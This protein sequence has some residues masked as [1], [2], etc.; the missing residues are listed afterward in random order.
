MVDQTKP[1]AHLQAQNRQ[2]DSDLP[3]DSV[4]LAVRHRTDVVTLVFTDIVGSTS[5]KHQLGDR[6]GVSL[7]QRHHAV[8]RECLAGFPAGKEDETAGDSFLIA[9]ATPSAAVAFALLLQARMRGFSHA[10]AAQLRD[11]IGIHLGEVV[12]QEHA[13]GLKPRELYGIQV[14]TCARVMDLAQAGQILLTR[15]A[16]DSARQML[17]GEDVVG[18]GPLAWLNHGSYLLKGIEASL[19]VCE[20]GEVGIAPLQAP[21]GSEKAQRQLTPESEAVLGWRPAV[22]QLVP[23][24]RWRLETKLGE[25]GFGEVWLGRHHHTKERRVFKFCFQAERVQF[26]KREMTLFRLLKDRVGRNPHFVQLHEVSL[27]EPPWYLMMEYVDAGDLAAWCSSQPPIFPQAGQAMRLEIV[28]QTAEALQAAHEA[29]ILHRDIKPANLLIETRDGGAGVQ[30]LI[31]DFGVGQIIA[32]ELLRSGTKFGFSHTVRDLKAGEFGGTLLYLAPEVLEGHPATARSDIYSLGVILWQLLIGNIHAALDPA[33]WPSRIQDPLLRE[34]LIRCLAGSPEKRWGTAGDLARSLRALPDR[35]AAEARRHA[36]LANRE[37]AA[38]RRGVL[39]TAGVAAAILTVMVALALIA[40]LQRRDLIRAQGDAEL[41]L[42]ATLPQWDHS[43][44]R[45]ERGM[46]YLAMAAGEV[47]NQPAL[48]TA[49]ARVFGM[50]DLVKVPFSRPAA[51][52]AA[53]ST[54]PT[55]PREACRML[56]HDGATLAVARDLDGLNGAIDL[57]DAVSGQPRLTIERRLFPWIPIAEPGLLRFSPNDKLLAVGGAKTSRQLLLFK[58]ADGALDSYLF[59]GSD[60]LACAWHPGDRLLATGCA[61]G[62]V[63]L[64]DTAAAVGPDGRGGSLPAGNQFDLPPALTAPALDLPAQTLPGNRGP[65]RFLAFSKHGQWLASL[66]N[67]G[68][69]RI[70]TG[71]SREGLPEPRGPEHG[72]QGPANSVGP[73]FAL[74]LR[75]DES[76]QVTALA[77]DDDHVKV[78]RGTAPA[79]EYWLRP[80]ELPTEMD[81]GPGITSVA[82]N[83]KW[84]ELCV[85][86]LSDIHWFHTS[87][88]EDFYTKSGRNP[89]GVCWSEADGFWAVCDDEW[90]TECRPAKRAENWKEEDGP[91]FPLAAAADNQGARTSLAATGDGRVAIYRGRR[92]Q[93]F[94]HR[95]MAPATS[96]IT[97]DGADGTFREIFWDQSGRLLGVVFALPSGSL[98]LET[99]ATST[100][101]PPI[102]RPLNPAALE[103][104]RIVPANDGRHCLLRGETAGLVLFDPQTGIGMPMDIS[105]FARQDWPLEATADGTLLAMVADGNKVRLLALPNGS[106]FA[107]LQSPRASPLTDL[108]WDASGHA[109]ACA[110][111]DHYIQVWN[112]SP[113]QDWIASHGLQK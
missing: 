6:A 98:R 99:W 80:G 45:R 15:S 14:D 17:K 109:F 67:A 23:K 7:I 9:F 46:H 81:V 33:E 25:G 37:R 106:L 75:L 4:G 95:L 82:W 68:Y 105:D 59:Q 10:S 108:T 97:A 52:P 41:N 112:L 90:L 87:P 84:T 22:G 34:D 79:E 71:F 21:A 92:I 94:A 89:V 102:C 3:D 32:N 43:A 11:R 42:A 39:R 27:D 62:I 56:S 73:L 76:Q 110:T 66:D 24:T 101:F 19:E 48:R 1:G 60:P 78:F 72:G 86:T 64:W 83:R 44:G 55:L 88:L 57:F 26:L 54:V 69:L 96:S 65:V 5:L 100:N 2:M 36:E 47:T 63:R 103:C 50:P 18:V 16:F 61:D 31:A 77:T 93:F 20:V 40:W 53:P 70:Q 49:S 30:V 85:T 91:A 111:K 28:A 107:E 38:Y 8:V 35:H 29:G 13:Q 12:V 113:W 74:E 51:K 58:V 104:Q